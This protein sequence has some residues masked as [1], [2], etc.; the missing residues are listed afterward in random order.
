MAYSLTLFQLQ[1]NVIGNT[2]I[3]GKNCSRVN[4]DYGKMIDNINRTFKNIPHRSGQ[5]TN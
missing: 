3:I 2:Q 1:Q 5:A 4:M